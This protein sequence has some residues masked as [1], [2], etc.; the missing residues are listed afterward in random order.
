MG[1]LIYLMLTTGLIVF[2]GS[3]RTQTPELIWIIA[4]IG[5]FSDTIS[6]NLLQK[7]IGTITPSEEAMSIPVSMHKKEE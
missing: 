7:I 5:S 6:T 3:S 1:A 4:F 2:A